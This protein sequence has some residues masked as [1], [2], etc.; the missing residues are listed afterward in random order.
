MSR[1]SSEAY[2]SWKTIC[3]S[4]RSGRRSSRLIPTSSVPVV[5]HRPALTARSAA[6]R[7]ARASTCPSRSRRPGPSVSRWPIVNDTSETAC[8]SRLVTRDAL[9]PAHREDLDELVDLDDRGR[10]R[11]VDV[12]HPPRSLTTR[13]APTSVSS[14][15]RMHAVCQVAER[16]QLG[17]ALGA[18]V[19]GVRA[20][21]PERAARRRVEHVRRRPGD[22]RQPLPPERRQA[23]QQAPGVRVARVVEDRPRRRRA[24]R[25]GRRT[26]PAPGRRRGRRRRGRG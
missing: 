20:A 10:R 15:A 14:S 2:G 8:T 12:G 24:R 9:G 25:P 17:Q 21:G 18:R 11:S 5:L 19:D 16:A 3:I 1:G 7:S 6:A 23:L 26:S 13:S 22:R 4:L